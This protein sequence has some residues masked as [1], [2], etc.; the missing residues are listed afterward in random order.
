ELNAKVYLEDIRIVL[1]NIVSAQAVKII[2]D[3]R[4]IHSKQKDQKANQA[5]AETKTKTTSNFKN[6]KINLN[7]STSRPDAI[8]LFTTIA[9]KNIPISINVN[10]KDTKIT[11]GV[12]EIA[13]F[14]IDL[15]KRNAKLN[16]LKLTL[17]PNIS[18][19]PIN[20]EIVVPYADYIII[21]SIVGTIDR[22]KIIF[23]SNP[24]LD[25]D[26]IMSMLFFGK[27][28]NEL[29]EG[30][31]ESV[32]S[33]KA[34]A[35]DGALTL[36]SLYFLSST[37]IESIG[38]NPETKA[39][40]AKIRLDSKTSITIGSQKGQEI[41]SLG[42]VEVRKKIGENFIISTEIDTATE[43]AETNIWTFLEWYNRY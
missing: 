42:S 11:D 23:D 4:I 29:N 20:S 41:S 27:Q 16:F 15:F 10:I 24:P 26:N 39:M 14:E 34:A 7:I 12:I 25:R 2:P 13:P 31:G 18:K 6:F 30:E 32:T 28:I 43:D 1:P 8:K 9:K 5:K 33:I 35:A 40:S 21:V 38:Y 3:T 19:S 22:P 37:P 17:K 36:A